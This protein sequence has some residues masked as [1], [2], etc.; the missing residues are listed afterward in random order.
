MANPLAL[1]AAQHQATPSPHASGLSIPS[2]SPGAEAAAATK[3]KGAVQ[4]L[5]Q[6]VG[7]LDPAS[8]MGQAVLESIKKLSKFSS[9]GQAMAGAEMT[10]LRNMQQRAQQMAPLQMLMSRLGGQE[11]APGGVPQQPEMQG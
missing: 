10:S 1:L 5:Q 4:I 7:D 8:D 11:G 6:L 3:I 9:H 2:A